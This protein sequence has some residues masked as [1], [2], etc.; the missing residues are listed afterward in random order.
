VF[1]LRRERTHASAVPE[2]T[3][4]R[5]PSRQPRW[6]R[7]PRRS[8][9]ADTE[10]GLETRQSE[11]YRQRDGPGPRNATAGAGPT[12]R[13]VSH[14]APRVPQ[15]AARMSQ[16]RECHKGREPWPED[17]PPAGIT[18]P[19]SGRTARCGMP[20]SAVRR[21]F[22]D[23]PPGGY[24]KPSPPSRPHDTARVP[25]SVR[26]VSLTAC[27]WRVR[28]TPP[29]AT[30]GHA[31]GLVPQCPGSGPGK[32]SRSDAYPAGRWPL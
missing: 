7:A 19:R 9:C 29:T 28:Q 1:P 27:R 18:S 31:A 3:Q 5:L 13:P 22:R 11:A 6:V 23:T 4:R 32:A 20:A 25:T 15:R 26:A 14:D 8:A 2:S 17:R 24:Y 21:G 10:D 12:T 16:P 30:A